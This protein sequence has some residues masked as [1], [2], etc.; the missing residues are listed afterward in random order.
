[1]IRWIETSRC[2]ELVH[3]DAKKLARI[4]DGGG[5]K[6]LGRAVTHNRPGRGYTH[7]HTAIDGYSRLAYSEFAGKE[8]TVNCVA[9]L[10]RAVTWFADQGIV[11]AACDC[12]RI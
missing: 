10:D 9:F 8:N 6:K 5:H 11:V 12:P 3:I 4:P 2:G 7:I 1:M